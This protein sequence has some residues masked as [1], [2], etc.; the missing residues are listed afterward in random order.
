VRFTTTPLAGVQLIDLERMVDDRGSFARSF[1]AQEFADHGLETTVAQCNVSVTNQ[2]GTLRGMHYQVSPAMEAK[3]VRC[4][5]G[6]IYDVVV[7]LRPGSA[8]LLHHFAV[9][10]SAA[11]GRGL[12]VPPGFAHGFQTLSD[13]VEV[14]Y[15]MST[16]YA[17]ELQRG[18]RYDDPVLAIDWPRPITQ[19]AARDASWPWLSAADVD[20]R[21]LAASLADAPAALI[22]DS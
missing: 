5:R 20:G 10:L 18:L 8:T 22:R 16:F 9:E 7:D 4:S 17:P 11:T 12:Y 1:C 2:A 14:L 3:L 21:L 15:Q 13:D 19:I 6:V